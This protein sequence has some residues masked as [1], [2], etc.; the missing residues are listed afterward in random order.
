MTELYL[1]HISGAT[2]A[3]RGRR[4]ARLLKALRDDNA[5]CEL[6]KLILNGYTETMGGTSIDSL[7]YEL[8]LVG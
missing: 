2:H 6:V 7:T 1:R 8:A 4:L 5:Q 3:L